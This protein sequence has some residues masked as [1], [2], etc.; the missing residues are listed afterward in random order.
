[1]NYSRR[2]IDSGRNE[3]NALIQNVDNVLYFMF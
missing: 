2:F 1:M 3:K